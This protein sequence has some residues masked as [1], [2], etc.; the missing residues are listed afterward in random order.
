[1][2]YLLFD[3]SLYNTIKAEIDRAVSQGAS[4]LEA[5]LDECPRLIS[6]YYEVLRLTSSSASIR[7]VEAPTPLGRYVLPS[8]TKVLLPFRQL[9]FN[10]DAFGGNT[11][12][13]DPERFLRDPSL[14]KSP[15]FRPFGGGSTYCPGRHVARREVLVFI[16]FAM[17]RFEL[18]LDLENDAVFPKLDTKKPSLGMMMPVAGQDVRVRVSKPKQEEPVHAAD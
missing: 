9:H 12:E 7:T 8:N 13:F 6:I 18:R 1:M 16:A 11:H 4:G 5:R 2:A 15:S 10:E 3:P 14:S 17:S